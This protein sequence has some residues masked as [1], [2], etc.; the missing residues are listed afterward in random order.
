VNTHIPTTARRCKLMIAGTVFAESGVLNNDIFREFYA[1][2]R[3]HVTN[4]TK[5]T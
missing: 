3:D 2:L 4:E 1:T 5:Y